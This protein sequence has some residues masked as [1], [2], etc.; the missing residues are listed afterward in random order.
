MVLISILAVVVVPRFFDAEMYQPRGFYDRVHTSLRYAHKVA[1][2]QN[3][4]VCAAF[5]ST[6]MTLTIGS[7]SA[8][9]TALAMPTGEASSVVGAPSGVT[10]TS[11]PTNFYFDNSGT[12][13]V[14][15]VI[16]V[17]GETATITIEATTGYIH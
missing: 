16:Q 6:S 12:P 13:S 2:A 7:T 17:S 8:C 11:L 9:G 5:T 10:F 4:F 14:S 3:R 15:Q 1:L